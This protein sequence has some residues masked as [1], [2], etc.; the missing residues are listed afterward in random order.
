M[1]YSSEND[2]PFEQMIKA[3]DLL[4]HVDLNDVPVKSKEQFD[5][6][7]TKPYGRKS[8]TR[9]A[10]EKKLLSGRLPNTKKPGAFEGA[11]GE[12]PSLQESIKNKGVER[13]LDVGAD[14]GRMT[15]WNGHN[16]LAAQMDLDPEAEL[17]VKFHEQGK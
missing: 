15:L 5:A 13:P 6:L 3:K 8:I 1:N 10:A 7:R 2:H 12:G 14:K 17:P 16:R 11:R 4:K 9:I